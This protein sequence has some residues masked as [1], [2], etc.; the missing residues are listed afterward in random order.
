MTSL[1][2]TLWCDAYM[3]WWYSMSRATLTLERQVQGI[4]GRR[5]K[6]LDLM[7]P[8]GRRREIFIVYLV[9]GLVVGDD[10]GV[11]D[12]D[13]AVGEDGAEEG[14]DDALRLVGAA[15]VAV[16]DVE[17]D[18]RL[19]PGGRRRGRGEE[20]NGALRRS[21]RQ[22]FFLLSSSSSASAAAEGRRRAKL[23][24]LIR[25]LFVGWFVSLRFG[26]YILLP[27]ERH[28]FCLNPSFSLSFF[29][30]VLNWVPR[31]CFFTWQPS[32]FYMP[33][34]LPKTYYKS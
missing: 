12:M 22:C 23:L 7:M 31:F 1:G 32:Y 19:H 34:R 4:N 30:T 28:N 10:V 2:L 14:A 6:T 8:G 11:A 20:E 17:H 29:F 26:F 13:G 9:G 24:F 33:H 16:A 5:S 3:L 25:V 18:D 21:H 27:G 15:H